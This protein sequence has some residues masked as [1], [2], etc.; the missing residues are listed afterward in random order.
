MIPA[1]VHPSIRLLVLLALWTL[2][3]LAA[4]FE[5]EI[6][7]LLREHCLDCHSAEKHKGDLDLERFATAAEIRRHPK[8][9]QGVV[10]QVA[11]GEMPPKDKSR[12]DAAGRERLLGWANGLLDEVALEHAGDP[13]PVVLR[14]LSNAEYTF[15]LRD[16][17]GVDSLDPARE[18]PADSA[19]GEG[20]MNVGNSLVMSPSLVTKYLDAAKEVAAH[21]VL[22]PD[23]LEFSPSTS[24]RDWT[25][26]TLAAIRAFYARY[27]E[28]G[29]GTAVNLQGIRFDTKDGGVLPLARYFEAALELRP[30]SGKNLAA[31]P[32]RI[33]AVA[34][35][36]G[37]N[38]RYLATLWKALADS[39][40][41]ALLD[42]L[43]LRWKAAKSGD[44]AALASDVA[45]WQ[46]AVWRFTTIGHIG[47]RDGPKAWQVPVTP[48]AEAREV[49]M[50]L[51]A[52]TNGGEVTLYLV[53]TDAG[54]GPEHDVAVWE[55]PRLVAP[56]RP[57]LPLRDVRA[58][59]A[60]LALH[61]QA[62]FAN[63]ARCLAVA[64]TVG[65]T[66]DATAVAALA[67]A[68]GLDGTVLAAWLEAL[69]IGTGE[70]RIDGHMTAKLESA[71]N[72]EFIQGWTGADALSVLANAS[73]QHVRV[74][75]NMKPH[76]VAVHPS[77]SRRA[78]V[79]WRSPVA[80]VL[81]IDGQVQHA[82]PECGNGV[83]WIL[84]LRRGMTR[85]ALAAGTAQGPKEV[86]FGPFGRIAVQPG[87]VVSLVVSPR[88]GNHSC[89]L[90][91][92]DL[93]LSDGTRD[94]D[95]A[96][97]VSPDILAGNP[98]ADRLGNGGVWHF[99]SEPDAGGPAEEALPAG[100]LLSRWQSEADPAAR[101]RLA[102]GVQALLTGGAA[103]LAAD[104]PDAVLHR[105]LTSLNGPLLR[106]ILRTVNSPQ[107]AGKKGDRRPK[108]GLDPALFGTRP[109][110]PK[111]ADTSLAVRAPSVVEVRLPADLA[112]GAEFVAT[113]TLHPVDGAEGSVQM[114][115][116]STR[117]A[118]LG[119]AAGKSRE[120]GG[121][122]TW[123]DGER[124]VDSDS[125]ILVRNGSAARRRI[126]AS[127]EE[128]RQLFP[129]ALCYTKIVP[130]DEVVTLTLYF[131]EDEHFRRL[132]LDDAQAAELDR[133][134]ARL[135][136]IS[137]DPLKLVDGFEQLWQFATQD[138][139]PSAFEPLRE[140]IKRRAEDFR[141]ELVAAQ[142]RHLDAVLKLAEKAYRRPLAVDEARDLAVLYQKLRDEELPHEQAIRL[143]LA[144]VFVAPAFL[145]RAE[146]AA[147][148]ATPGPV[149]D[150]ELATRLSYFLWS[151][152]PDDE[153]RALA[154]NG[155][156]HS[157][158]VLTAQARRMLRDPKV[159]RL[160]SEFAAAWLH[161][162]GFEELAEK[163]E[164]HFPTFN[165]L[166]GAMY[167]ET[168]RFFTDLFQRDGSV[169]E[170]LDADHT[171]LNAELARHYGI[172]GVTGPGWRRVDGVKQYSRGGIL[173]QA[174][175]LAKQSGASRTSPILRGNW[176]CEVLLGER[177]PRP[178]KDVPR[179][180]EDEATESLTVRQLTEKHSTDP[181]CYGCHMRIDPYGFSLE[182]FDAIGRLRDKDLGGHPVD[183]RAKAMDGAEFEGIN[184]LRGYLLSK[185]RD[186]FLKQFCR[187]LLGYSL[188]RGVMLSDGPL[189]GGM[190][191]Q[192]KSHDHRFASAVDSIVLSRQFREVRGKE[193]ASDD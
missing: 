15:T 109:K 35:E 168:L 11:L 39:R 136:F 182:A 98:H 156:L 173:G 172:P 9:W 137:Q 46:Q 106:G 23:G 102:A 131:R 10:E 45:Q 49:R 141:K 165:G 113:T 38:A 183:T 119:L 2:A 121:K 73:D 56:G 164:R 51:A 29:G 77:P 47:K 22:L 33:V 20:F 188:G 3:S 16:L 114:Q 118:S 43:R 142:P 190:R 83:A 186:A 28:N 6:R 110:G 34:T 134:W 82:H 120:Q 166:R 100:S 8:V 175:T 138:A 42:P 12:L 107:V 117:P 91:A 126:E 58:A 192:L 187:K 96:K 125:P 48:L 72:Y 54:D 171:F 139:D 36:R 84:E 133:L 147:P 176:L 193:M 174:T 19:S 27:T 151:S 81:R 108:P 44:G 89:D 90:T 41:S 25:E 123:S 71:Q 69:G 68:N 149:D 21:A 26:E 161:I 50:K 63:A 78:V 145:Y 4:D 163:S 148:G 181:R 97:D 32:E 64:A 17:T 116:V 191:D 180:P 143:T 129:A 40:P 185:R 14:R 111:V 76:G 57:E 135:H 1:I 179:L 74:P 95:L 152:A 93:R 66:N 52:P 87:D 162:Y 184:G 146:K 65:A 177:L 144:R 62:V 128:F 92:V 55:N 157:P 59:A 115:A 80:S 31:S 101:V 112:E 53:T 88:D 67:K 153:L 189:V 140:P 30:G 167:E 18:F 169:L 60:A 132:M 86:P 150:W 159:R 13:G 160:A 79:S 104:S 124:P 122:G 70:A 127:L 170:I 61:R 85:Q 103:G 7:P 154:A 5:S 155:T 99:H 24:P 37:L 130:V 158:E 75:G 178:P 94:W 105:R